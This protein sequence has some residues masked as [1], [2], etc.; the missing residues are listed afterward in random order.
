M[1]CMACLQGLTVFVLVEIEAELQALLGAFALVIEE[2][3]VVWIA[4]E[5]CTFE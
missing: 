2:A 1:C 3:D 5:R 4:F